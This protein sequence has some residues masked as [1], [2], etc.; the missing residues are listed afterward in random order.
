MR[1]NIKIKYIAVLFIGLF[2]L[3]CAGDNKEKT[4]GIHNTQSNM[5][6]KRIS[7]KVVSVADGDTITL[8]DNQN[9]EHKIRL[10]CIDTPEKSQDFGKRAKK[11]LSS[12]IGGKSIS[13]DK[14]IG[15]CQIRYHLRP[16]LS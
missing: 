11:E 14:G 10:S 8:L 15:I 3:A 5:D 13:R 6:H 4:R 12:M 16:Y 9:V 1:I 2:L 7:G